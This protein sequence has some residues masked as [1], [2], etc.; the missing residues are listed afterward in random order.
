[1][2]RSE[3]EQEMEPLM[4]NDQYLL[5]NA[6]DEAA[7]RFAGLSALF[8]P[9]TFSHLDAVGISTGWRC[10]EVGA[11]GP[12]VPAWMVRRVG[13]AGHVVATDIDTRWLARALADQAGPAVEVRTHDVARDDPPEGAFDLV[14]ARLV[15]VHVPD[16]AEALRRMVGALRPGGWLVLEDFDPA[17]VAPACLEAT[18]PAQERA[19]KI[20][21]GFIE[22]LRRRQVDVQYGRKLPRLLREAGLLDVAADAY[23]PVTQPGARRLEQANTLQVAAGLVAAGLA[24]QAELDAHLAALAEGCIDVATPPLISAWGRR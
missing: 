20:R 11:G 16:R 2:E 19:N 22:L 14:H 3:T 15:L 18:S 1:V 23:F 6:A 4:A 7:D 24:T 17:L 13:G 12:S 5:D 10:W 8:D 21:A 9:V